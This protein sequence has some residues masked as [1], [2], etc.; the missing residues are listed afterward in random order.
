[1]AGARLAKGTQQFTTSLRILEKMRGGR[2]HLGKRMVFRPTASWKVS[3]PERRTTFETTEAS[4][5]PIIEVPGKDK[6]TVDVRGAA[7]A[8]AASA[9]VAAGLAT[10]L[11]LAALMPALKAMEKA[12]NQVERTAVEVERAA[13]DTRKSAVPALASLERAGKQWEEVGDEVRMGLCFLLLAS[14]PFP[15]CY[16]A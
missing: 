4:S 10:F 6:V 3:E 16:G 13:E 2:K 5:Q 11:V 14:L 1:M 8:L 9:L 15:V 12:S 7:L